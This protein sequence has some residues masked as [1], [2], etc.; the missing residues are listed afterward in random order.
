MGH[1][2]VTVCS[3][4]ASAGETMSLSLLSEKRRHCIETMW[5][6]PRPGEFH[7]PDVCPTPETLPR[8]FSLSCLDG[9]AESVRSDARRAC[10]SA[11]PVTGLAKCRGPMSVQ[12][13]AP[14]S[15]HGLM[16]EKT[17]SM[18]LNCVS[19]ANQTLYFLHLGRLGRRGAVA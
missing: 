16:T 15:R 7:N 2:K 18:Y 6:S 3:C 17:R 13:S 4:K 12:C 8:G 10:I 11:R 14:V 1:D 9:F 5:T 19:G